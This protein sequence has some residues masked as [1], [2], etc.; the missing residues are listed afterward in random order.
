MRPIPYTRR[1]QGPDALRPARIAREVGLTP[2]TVRERIARL[3][4]SGVVEGYEAVPNLRHLGLEA[5]AYLLEVESEEARA[6]VEEAAALLDG[7]IEVS[8][9]LGPRMC[10]DLAHRTTG[11]RD[12]RI[13]ALARAAGDGDP[14]PFLGWWMPPVPRRLT[15]LDWRIVRELREDPRRSL[16]D[17]AGTLGLGYRTI[18]R[19]YDRMTTEGSLFTKPL[20][21]PGKEPGLLPA[22]LLF[23]FSPG[24]PA[25]TVGAI[26][27]AFDDQLVFTH[28]PLSSRY[29]NVDALVFATSAANV[30]DLARRGRAIPGVARVDAEILAGVASHAAWIDDLIEAQASPA[31]GSRPRDPAK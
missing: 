30:Q 24:A 28:E 12:R 23:H 29:G 21:N 31:A 14:A 17:V 18:K 9:F 6:R 22:V 19:H 20:L 16:P 2:E 1:P 8:N 13:A 7:V 27:A 5:T 15:P 11:E 26:A 3:E 10:V 25:G 4:A